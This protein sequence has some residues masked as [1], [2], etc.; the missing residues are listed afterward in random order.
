MGLQKKGLISFCDVNSLN[1]CFFFSAA[2]KSPVCCVALHVF[3]FFALVH[4]H[5]GW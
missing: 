4:G 1:A 3:F 2:K 5:C